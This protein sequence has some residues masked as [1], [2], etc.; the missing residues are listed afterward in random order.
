MVLSGCDLFVILTSHSSIPVIVMLWLTGKMNGY[1]GWVD[2]LS[3]L[4]ANTQGFSIMALVVMSFDRY[5][6][7][8]RPIYHRTSITK[9][10][11]MTLLGI[12]IF[13]QLALT[14]MSVNKFISLNLHALVFLIIVGPPLMFCNCKLFIIARKNRRKKAVS[15]DLKKSFSF[16]NVSSCLLTVACFMVL[17]TP[18]V[19]YTALAMVSKE[20]PGMSERVKLSL[21]WGKTSV[22]M[23]ST[24]NCLIF[25]WKNK[26][27]R[28]EG[29]KIIKGM[30]ICRPEH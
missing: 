9:R 22:A 4:A 1:P 13:V 14:L 30:K 21:L 18:T 3:D 7:T 24:F 20:A 28:T 26:V 15:P 5:L 27:L 12:L 19:I 16:K 11:L 2:V 6:A 25:Y 8:Y 29:I 17:Q 10:K 23:T